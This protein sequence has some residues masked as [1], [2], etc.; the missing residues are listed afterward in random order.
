MGNVLVYFAE[1][2]DN[3]RE[4]LKCSLS[5]FGYDIKGFENGKDLVNE[6]KVQKPNV[7]ILDIMMPVMDGI[8]ALKLIKSENKYNDIPIIMLTAKTQEM[9]KVAG[10]DSGADDYMVKPFSILE[11]NSRIK[12]MLRRTAKSDNFEYKNIV[13]DTGK[14]KVVIDGKEIDLTLKEFEVL[15]LLIHNKDKVV[16]RTDLLHKVWGYDY[17][18]ETRTLDMHIKT[19]RQKI[20]DTPDNPKYIKT[21]R[22][23][24]YTL[25]D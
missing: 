25:V 2:D 22:G 24:G 14:H 7:I 12:A 17:I 6:I 9:D 23:I 20:H 3:I 10:L 16:S 11:L 5:S 8:E 13:L 1:D 4:L 21:V 19:L 15:N 18:G